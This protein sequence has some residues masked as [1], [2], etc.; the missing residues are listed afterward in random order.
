MK[1]RKQEHKQKNKRKVEM[2]KTMTTKVV[3][4]EKLEKVTKTK[5]RS[6]TLQC[7]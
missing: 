7:K 5:R 2:T 6:I 1:E 3:K 4:P